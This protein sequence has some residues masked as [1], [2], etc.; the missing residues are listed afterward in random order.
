MALWQV[1]VGRY[2]SVQSGVN[3]PFT[4]HVPQLY[5]ATLTAIRHTFPLWMKPHYT[6]RSFPAGHHSSAAS[7]SSHL[8]LCHTLGQLSCCTSHSHYLLFLFL[9]IEGKEE[10]ACLNSNQILAAVWQLVAC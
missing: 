3:L 7:A 4:Y 2:L 1:T 5:L 6:T 8:C 9:Y 10:T